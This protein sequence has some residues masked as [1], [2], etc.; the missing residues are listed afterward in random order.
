MINNFMKKQI[1]KFLEDLLPNQ[2]WD[3]LTTDTWNGV[4][5][6]LNIELNANF[7]STIGVVSFSILY[8]QKS[9]RLTLESR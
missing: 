8:K 4:V 7:L 9:H 1:A 3:D 6:K 5:S 2:N